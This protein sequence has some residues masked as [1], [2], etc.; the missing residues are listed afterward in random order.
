MGLFTKLRIGLALGSGG[1]RGLSHI[2]VIKALEA[3][4]I[5]IHVITGSSIGAL[6]GGMYAEGLN[7]QDVEK[8]VTGFFTSEEFQETGF[9]LFRAE[10]HPENFYGQIAKKTNGGLT[11]QLDSRRVSLMKEHRLNIVMDRLLGNGLVENTRIKFAPVATNLET[12]EVV[13]FRSG[14]LREAVKSSSSIPGF[15]PPISYRDMVLVDG[16]V[17]ASIPVEPAFG[18]G[19]DFVIAVNVSRSLEH[20]PM[21]N[22]VMDVL[23]RTNLITAHRNDMLAC[24]KAQV[25]LRPNVGHVHW[26][27]FDRFAELISEGAKCA[28]AGID[29]IKTLVRKNSG[30]LVRHAFDQKFVKN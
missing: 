2:G 22:N 26:T 19:A 25:V 24:E 3:H 23:F 18:L 12:G 15:L 5:P 9:K 6:V 16:G 28:E 29:L 10:L 17:A 27:E 13:V 8:R 21:P 7:I 20:E 30:R 11:I 4:Q 14:S 1:A